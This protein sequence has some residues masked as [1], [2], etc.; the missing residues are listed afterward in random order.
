MLQ[1]VTSAEGVTS[2]YFELLRLATA[3][4]AHSPAQRCDVTLWNAAPKGAPASAEAAS[5][6]MSVGEEWMVPARLIRNAR[7][8]RFAWIDML[9]T[10][11]ATC[12]ARLSRPA[13]LMGTFRATH[14]CRIRESEARKTPVAPRPDP[15]PVPPTPCPGL[16]CAPRNRLV[17]HRLRV[18][19][20]RPG[21]CVSPC[22]S[23]G[24]V[25]ASA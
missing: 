6:A 5:L 17:P 8:P 9:T 10:P 12:R 4:A 22:E 3:D 21:P 16:P 25:A 18:A 19:S 11:A 2:S 24:R 7:T 1:A 20:G 15:R 23:S 14:L 13:R